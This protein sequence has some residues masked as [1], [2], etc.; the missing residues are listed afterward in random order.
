MD[1][2]YWITAYIGCEVGEV[3]VYDSMYKTLSHNSEK[4]ICSMWPTGSQV[5]FNLA[6]I[7]R[8]PNNSD[9]GLFAVVYMQQNSSNSGI[10]HH[11]FGTRA[12]C[13]NILPSALKVGEWRPFRSEG[14]DVDHWLWVLSGFVTSSIR[15]ALFFCFELLFNFISML[16][17]L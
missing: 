7:Q 4:Q 13:G 15:Y 11:V 2:V 17:D 6:N 10:C 3:I 1:Q 16:I 9:C 12:R 14:Q 8:S 5:T